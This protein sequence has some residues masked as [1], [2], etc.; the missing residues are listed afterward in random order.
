MNI[1]QSNLLT[2][3]PLV[4]I[5]IPSYNRMET[6]KET[7][8]S[9]LNQRCDF[10]Y[11]IIV[12]DDNSTDNVR[13][14]LFDYKNKYPEQIKLILHDKNIGLGANWATCA[15]Q[16][17]GKYL[18]NCDN[19]DYWHNPDKLQLE[20]EFLEK[21]DQYGVVYTDY[22]THN[23]SNQ[24]IQE[25]Q[26]FINSNIPLQKAIFSGKYKL[27]NATIIYKKELI[28]KHIPLDDYIRYQ[29]SLQDWNTWLILAKY[30]SFYHLPI[31][32]ATF[33][34]ETE[35]IT[36]PKNYSQIEHRFKKEKEC[37]QYLCNLFRDDLHFDEK[38]YDT[39][40]LS[41]LLNLA[42]KRF[43]FK[44]AKEYAKLLMQQGS[45]SLKVKCA[46][47]PISFYLFIFLKRIKSKTL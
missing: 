36:R 4:S 37:Y 45:N 41:I 18:A 3:H 5:I 24:Q 20:V 33:G 16:A 11:E 46:M 19:D 31:S 22:R 8:D 13:D 7:L 26:A 39:Y 2:P 27:C 34:I 47:N 10:P 21:Y 23:R 44:K 38:G 28:D 1:I 30:T 32:T 12:G 6:I 15:K 43:D 40:V 29:F 14:I 25:H 17:R 9:L 35:S 42:Y